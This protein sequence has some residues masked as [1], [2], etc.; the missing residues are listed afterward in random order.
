[1]EEALAYVEAEG[2]ISLTTFDWPQSRSW[3]AQ[4]GVVEQETLKPKGLYLIP[5]EMG[6][7]AIGKELY[8]VLGEGDQG[9]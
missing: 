9:L 8:F 3:L 7:P 5:K 1:M 6:A 4:A 2:L